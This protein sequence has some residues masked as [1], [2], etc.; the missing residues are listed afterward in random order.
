MDNLEQFFTKQEISVIQKFVAFVADS[1]NES[2]SGK[3]SVAGTNNE[4]DSEI[5]SDIIEWLENRYKRG[6]GKRRNN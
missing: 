2:N 3:F 4:T 6:H 5:K 1:N